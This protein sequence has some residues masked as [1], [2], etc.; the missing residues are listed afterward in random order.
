MRDFSSRRFNSILSANYR[1]NYKDKIRD[2][3]GELK[4][5]YVPRQHIWKKRTIGNFRISCLDFLERRLNEKWPKTVKSAEKYL[6]TRKKELETLETKLDSKTPKIESLKD[7]EELLKFFPEKAIHP[8]FSK[9]RMALLEPDFEGFETYFSE[10]ER[11][12][13]ET[14]SQNTNL[15]AYLQGKVKT[16][17]MLSKARHG[18]SEALRYLTYIPY[19]SFKGSKFKKTVWEEISTQ[20]VK[21]MEEARPRK[22]FYILSELNK[23]K[24]NEEASITI[25]NKENGVEE[26]SWN[27]L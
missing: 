10:E 23:N 14:A 9:I 18:F 20:R 12:Q 27:E 21:M 7:K 6:K 24:E 26:K 3:V 11:Q 5:I 22:L 19:R 8:T 25:I 1:E 13:L 16:N 4:G 2:I 17:E 15:L